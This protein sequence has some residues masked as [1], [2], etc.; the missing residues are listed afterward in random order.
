MPVIGVASITAIDSPEA[1][2]KAGSPAGK[3]FLRVQFHGGPTVD[4]TC[5]LAEMLGGAAKGTRE[6]YEAAHG[7][8]TEAN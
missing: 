7:K 6:R 8:P 1:I 3:P 5:N 2:E 4:L